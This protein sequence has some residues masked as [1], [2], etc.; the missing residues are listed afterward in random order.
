MPKLRA[1]F[2]GGRSAETRVIGIVRFGFFREAAMLPPLRTDRSMNR[3][4]H[5]KPTLR[6]MTDDRL[7]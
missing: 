7:T 6:E 1:T 5:A 3:C 2:S 4:F